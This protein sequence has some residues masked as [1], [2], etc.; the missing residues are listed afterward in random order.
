MPLSC[1]NSD[2][3][4]ASTSY[5]RR[6]LGPLMHRR[7]RDASGHTR[8]TRGGWWVRLVILVIALPERAQRRL[9]GV[10]PAADDFGLPR[11]EAARSPFGGHC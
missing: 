1:C 7:P 5:P 10:Q 8:V 2:M 11:I 4:E 3:N 6:E 9:E